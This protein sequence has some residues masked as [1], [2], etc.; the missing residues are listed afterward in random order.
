MALVVLE[1]SFLSCCHRDAWTGTGA[2]ADVPA[3]RVIDGIDQL[4][5]LAGQQES[6][7]REGYLYWMGPELYG[8]KWRNFKLALAVQKY[9]TDPAPARRIS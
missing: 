5:W 2:A 8:V 1:R 7:G 3:D 9:S 4:P 6:S